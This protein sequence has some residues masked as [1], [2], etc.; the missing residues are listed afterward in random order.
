MKDSSQIELKKGGFVLTREYDSLCLEMPSKD[1]TVVGS[2]EGHRELEK[3]ETNAVFDFG[4]RDG[5]FWFCLCWMDQD[6]GERW[7]TGGVT[8]S[9]KVLCVQWYKG[10]LKYDL[11]V[12]ADKLVVVVSSQSATGETVK[13]SLLIEL[14]NPE[15]GDALQSIMNRARPPPMS[16]FAQ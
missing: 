14:N 12:S 15:F 6:G 4:R 11:R 8:W 9:E 2:L 13:R 3:N 5:T 1:V 16:L 7:S 10:V